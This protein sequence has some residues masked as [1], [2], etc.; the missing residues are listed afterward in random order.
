MQS[1]TLFLGNLAFFVFRIWPLL[2]D[3]FE[4]GVSAKEK[5]ICRVLFRIGKS[6]SEELHCVNP[7]PFGD[8]FADSRPVGHGV[9][10]PC[11]FHIFPASQD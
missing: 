11:H 9:Q 2:L 10:L 8:V 5:N 3:L 1:L 6:F 4:R 7:M